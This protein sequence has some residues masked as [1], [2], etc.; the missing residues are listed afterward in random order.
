MQKNKRPI[1][2]AEITQSEK[3]RFDP[4]QCYFK[5]IYLRSNQQRQMYLY[6]VTDEAPTRTNE[7]IIERVYRSVVQAFPSDWHQ[8]VGTCAVLA[9]TNITGEADI[10]DFVRKQFITEKL[11]V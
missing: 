9:L 4:F 3:Y 11:S 8:Q 6:L 7:L 2:E 1:D 5:Y 10:V